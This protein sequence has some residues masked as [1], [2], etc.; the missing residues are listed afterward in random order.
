MF[1]ISSPSPSQLCS[2]PD[3]PNVKEVSVIEAQFD[4][5]HS[6]FLFQKELE[7]R[8]N[9]KKKRFHLR[10]ERTVDASAQRRGRS[11]TEDTLHLQDDKVRNL[12]SSNLTDTEV[13]L[14]FRYLGIL[15]PSV[16]AG[17]CFL[18]WTNFSPGSELP[19]ENSHVVKDDGRPDL[20]RTSGHL[21]ADLC[22]CP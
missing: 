6:F 22:I 18:F 4:F 9:Q 21:R 14:Y 19:G 16:E 20:D 10:M 8:E 5:N 11:E 7:K 13:R 1:F 12:L 15:A 3:K 17:Q 2:A